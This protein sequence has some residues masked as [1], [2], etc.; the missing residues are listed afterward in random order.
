MLRTTIAGSL[1]Y[2]GTAC[3]LA[4]L[5]T[6]AYA[7]ITP[8]TNCQGAYNVMCSTH[9][10]TCETAGTGYGCSGAHIYAG[11]PYDTGDTAFCSGSSTHDCSAPAVNCGLRLSF[12][13]GACGRCVNYTWLT[14]PCAKSDACQLIN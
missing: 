2:I 11:V 3:L 7:T 8:D 9:P 4:G 14:V 12:P 10:C 13:G 5:V 1:F 6:E